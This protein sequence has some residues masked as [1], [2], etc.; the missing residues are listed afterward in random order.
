M[1][2]TE[3]MN[4]KSSPIP[5]CEPVTVSSDPHESA[6]LAFVILASVAIY[7][8][9]LLSIFGAFYAVFI[10]I[11]VFF[12]H[13]VFIA[14]VRGSGVK[15][16][17][18]QFP[19]LYQRVHELAA[20][21]GMN[22]VPDSYLMQEG[23]ALNAFATKLF[24]GRIIVLYTDV[25]EACG[26][27]EAARD[28]IIGHELGH[29][30][31]GHL[32]W[33]WLTIPGRFVPLLGAAYSRACERTCDRWGAALCG[34][35][36][37]AVRGL[38]ILA[39]GATFAPHVNLAAFVDQQRDLDTGWM[40][41]GRWLSSYPPLAERIELLQP[42]A[43]SPRTT[44]G[45]L[46]A[47]AIISGCLV[48]PMAATIIAGTIWVAAINEISEKLGDTGNPNLNDLLS[49]TTLVPT[50]EETEELSNQAIS[51]M[52]LIAQTLASWHEDGRSF[53]E[54]PNPCE[55]WRVEFPETPCP[56]DPFDG[57]AYGLTID[58]DQVL[59]FSSGPDGEARTEDDLEY[60][61]SLPGLEGN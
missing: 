8:S 45:P 61:I 16:G 4:T 43:S 26:D 19:D 55:F 59:I 58:W 36:S 21:A 12:G 6:L 1:S 27:D 28:M 60:Q 5:D 56:K 22:Q 44:R 25:L 41:L 30:K 10:A 11:F 9:L 50:D 32:D 13:V 35:A 46:R 40:T 57:F 38:A 24:R 15:L 29:H 42:D 7:G 39:V 20:R 34:D 2:Y 48:L 53:G 47:V 33:L 31:A 49:D 17:P 3:V 37:G 18:E 23:G 51:D 14:H 52:A 54:E